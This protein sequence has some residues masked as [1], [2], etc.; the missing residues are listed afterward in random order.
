MNTDT[1]TLSIES[2]WGKFYITIARGNQIK[3][4]EKSK[5]QIGQR[6]ALTRFIVRANGV[7]FPKSNRPEEAH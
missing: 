2:E 4:R 6:Q 5:N 7:S 1:H 3:G